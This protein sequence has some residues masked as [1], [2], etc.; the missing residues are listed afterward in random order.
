MDISCIQIGIRR[1][2]DGARHLVRVL[3]QMKITVR[4][5]AAYREAIGQKE[6]TLDVP[7][8]TTPVRVWTLL[9]ERFPAIRRLPAPSRFAVDDDFVDGGRPLEAGDVLALIPP[10]SGGKDDGGTATPASTGMSE[11]GVTESVSVSLTRSQIDLQRLIAEVADPLAGAVVLFT[12]TVRDLSRGRS[13]KFL[14]YEAY[15]ALAEKEMRRIAQEAVGKWSLRRVAV[16]HRLGRL[17]IEEVSVAIAVSSPHR[18]EAFEA[19]RFIIDTLKQTVPIWKKEVW[20]Q[21]E[22]WISTGA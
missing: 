5:F 13:V 6:V 7:T 3:D 14:E 17:D 10:V 4:A 12:G 15:E 16:V 11:K 19:A 1:T 2:I 9:A 22:E 18:K 20:G 21:G 8:G